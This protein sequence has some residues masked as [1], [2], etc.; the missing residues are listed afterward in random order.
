VLFLLNLR[1]NASRSKVGV[2][3]G[4]FKKRGNSDKKIEMP[5]T[6]G[7]GS[8]HRQREDFWRTYNTPWPLGKDRGGVPA[9]AEKLSNV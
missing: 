7:G 3:K 2:G 6:N 5:F 8:A 9:K 4:P 1:E